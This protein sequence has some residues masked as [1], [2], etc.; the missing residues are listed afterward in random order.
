MIE[1][2]EYIGAG[3]P[4]P[5]TSLQEPRCDDDADTICCQEIRAS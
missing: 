1:A 2:E 3:D 5:N 4:T